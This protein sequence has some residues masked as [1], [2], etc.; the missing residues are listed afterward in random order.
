[1][2]WFA[3]KTKRKAEFKASDFF[4]LIGVNSYVPS[5]QT[6]RVW[7]DRIKKVTVPA[8][9]GYVFFELEKIN[10][11]LLNTNPF[12]RNIVRTIDG[13]PAI[14]KE[15]EIAFLKKHLSGE[16]TGN[17]AE[18]YKGQNIKVS[19]GP[20]V[21]KK[22]VINKVCDNKIIINIE[23]INVSLILNKSSVVAA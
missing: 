19:S 8:I 11:E 9:T 6:K 21:F 2:C 14:I 13:S 1:M 23:S 20:F 17:E 16:S 3:A 5:Y 12:T 18:F 15:S 4:N 22:G 7:S 10:F